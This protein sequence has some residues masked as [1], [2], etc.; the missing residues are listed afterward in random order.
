LT[1]RHPAPHTKDVDSWYGLWSWKVRRRHQLA[2]YPLCAECERNGR[3]TPAEVAD[4]DP[5]HGNDWNKFRLG[6]LRSLC[7]ECHEEAHGR[8]ARV[9][10]IDE[11][12]FPVDSAHPFNRGVGRGGRRG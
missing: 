10:E 5:P 2:E 1:A 7:R 8:R 6:P 4:H 11:H 9:A 3:V 12:G